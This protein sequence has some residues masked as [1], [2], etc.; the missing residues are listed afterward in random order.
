MLIEFIKHP[1]LS[2]Y[3]LFLVLKKLIRPDTMITS[4]TLCVLCVIIDLFLEDP[5]ISVFN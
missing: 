1:V 5:V 2:I 3:N 4:H